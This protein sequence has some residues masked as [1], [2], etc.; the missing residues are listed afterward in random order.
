[1]NYH[2]FYAKFGGSARTKNIGPAERNLRAYTL[3]DQSGL[4]KEF[5]RLDPWEMEYLFSVARRARR[6]I[7]ETGRY[8]GGS[9][10]LMACA[11]PDVP[12]YSIDLAPKDDELLRQK[13]AEHGIGGKV[14][15]IV[16]DSQKQKYPQIGAVDVLFIDG[17]HSYD[18]CMNDMVNWYDHLCVNGHLILHDS[19]LGHWGVQD[20]I[21]DFMDMHQELQVIQSPFI[22][23]HYWHYPAGSMAHLI[24]RASRRWWWFSRA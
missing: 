6:G 7:I 13:F 5:I 11:A 18:G 8:N 1:V 4:P 3:P 19:Y 20:A 15:L 12:I 9:C 24:K 16:G 23:A 22:G 2:E 14:D 10:F 17:D 21:A